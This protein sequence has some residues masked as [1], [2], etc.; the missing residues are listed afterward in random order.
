MTD[1]TCLVSHNIML[2]YI[3][4][5]INMSIPELQGNNELPEGEHLASLDE[6]E[7]TYGSSTH[8]R[9][10]LVRGLLDAASNMKAAGVKCIW[11]NGSFVTNKREPNDI[12]GCW[13]YD[14]DVNLGVL[15][16]AFLGTRAEMKK[17]YG[18]DFFIA[19]VI[20]TGSGLPFPK[21]FQRNRDGVPKGIIMVKLRRAS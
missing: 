11:I 16:P 2:I 19:N 8:R 17:K 10:E 1:L 15:D 9:K 18:L 5:R 14:A 3:A 4:I 21:F 6:I 12:D 13:E 20:E 7:I